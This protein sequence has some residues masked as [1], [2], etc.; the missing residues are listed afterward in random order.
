M[1]YYSKHIG[2][3]ATATRLL[4]LTERGAYNELMDYYY[5][6]EKPLPANLDAL[7]RIAGAFSEQE[8]TAVDKVS[9]QF[10]EEVDGQLFQAK[11][12]DQI[13]A[14]NEEAEKNRLNGGK[15]GRPPKPRENP[16]GNP[17][18]TQRQT[19]KK[20]NPVTSNHISKPNGLDKGKKAPAAPFV[21]PDWVPTDTWIDFVTMRKQMRKPMGEA[22]IRLAVRTLDDLRSKGNDP[23]AVIEQ[24]ILR[25]W[26][27]FFPLRGDFARRGS[28]QPLRNDRSAAAAAIFGASS[29]PS[30]VIDV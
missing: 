10:F 20:A 28:N 25:G 29:A 22:A 27:G 23:K 24:S 2:D 30:E 17:E 6:T 7:C 14:Y 4:S 9:Q 19:E 15:G 16:L 5:A 12:E 8:R 13:L 18:E 11:I 26:S 1:K 3:F 21:I